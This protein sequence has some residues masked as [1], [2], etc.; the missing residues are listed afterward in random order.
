MQEPIDLVAVAEEKRKAGGLSL[1]SLVSIVLHAALI[2]WF[3]S[4]YKPV[5]TVAKNEPP[6]QRYIEF[7]KQNPQEFVEAPGPEAMRRAPLTAPLS[8]KNRR[9]SMPEPTGL[10][11][12]TRPGDGSGLH[13]PSSNPAPRGPQLSAGSPAAPQQQLTEASPATAPSTRTLL[14]ETFIYREPVKASA[15]A[16]VV[17]W[18]SAIRDAGR[19]AAGSGGD[20]LDLG[21]TGGEEGFAAEQGPISFETQWYDW[22]DYAQSMVSKIRVNWYSNMPQLIRTGM[23]GVV[24]IRFTIHRDGNISD[25]T[26]LNSSTREPY[27]FA[28][29]KAIKLSS[30]LKPLPKDFPH[31]TERVTCIFYYNTAVPAG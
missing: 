2:I 8:D 3:I 1:S 21:R 13:V 14:D 17:D 10:R 7:L 31:A 24:T 15:A 4:S 12:T 19:A 20:G 16:G 29:R 11:P 18:R 25:I 6:I 22:G 28:A 5:P 27:D 23:A 26:I 30:P 9:A